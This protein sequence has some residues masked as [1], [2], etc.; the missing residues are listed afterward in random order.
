[1][2]PERA[3]GICKKEAGVDCDVRNV[4]ETFT[5]QGT[6]QKCIVC[7]P[8]K[9]KIVIPS[10]TSGV[11]SEGTGPGGTSGLELEIYSVLDLF[12]FFYFRPSTCPI[13]GLVAVAEIVKE[14]K[15]CKGRHNNYGIPSRSCM[16]P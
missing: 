12:A 2:P 8:L 9:P 13:H 16:P 3:R 4:L 14:D 11:Q 1:M 5:R 7:T 10:S 15:C 6:F